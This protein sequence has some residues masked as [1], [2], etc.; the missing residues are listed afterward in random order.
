VKELVR[1]Q[2]LSKRYGDRAVLRGVD[3]ALRDGEIAGLIGANGAGKTTLLRILLGLVRPSGGRVEWSETG[4]AFP[5]TAVEHFGGAHTLSPR[6]TARTWVALVSRGEA[7]CDDRRAIRMLSRGSRQLLGLRTVLA[8][9]GLV[10]VFL[11]EPWE[12]LDPDGSRWLTD[13]L[14]RK[15]DEG[16]AVLVSSHR[17]HDLAG[18]CDRY[19]FL[20][21]GRAVI[22]DAAEISADPVRGEDLLRAFDRIRCAP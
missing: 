4:G 12:G 3:Y 9:A 15:R 18:L 6:V 5:P 21:E 2:R 7:S 13:T 10:A 20:L 16:C 19:A 1:A 11:D 17:L 22:R 14:R 8:R